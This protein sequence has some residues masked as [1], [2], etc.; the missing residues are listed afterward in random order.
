V[1]FIP[2]YGRRGWGL[3]LMRRAE[4]ALQAVSSLFHG[5]KRTPGNLSPYHP[6]RGRTMAWY[7]RRPCS[8]IKKEDL[9]ESPVCC[10]RPTLP[11]CHP[12]C[13]P[14]SLVTDCLP[15]PR[16]SWRNAIIRPIYRKYIGL[17]VEEYPPRQW[18]SLI[19][20]D[21]IPLLSKACLVFWR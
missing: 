14:R 18:D 12:D 16:T 2:I 19:G 21:R 20:R 17:S 4:Q 3:E 10:S 9:H 5:E 6:S 13:P 11:G 15:G 1:T 8:R 7:R